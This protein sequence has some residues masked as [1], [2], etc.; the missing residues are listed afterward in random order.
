MSIKG[1]HDMYPYAYTFYLDGE[2]YFVKCNVD[3]NSATCL[4]ELDMAVK[5][6]V[7]KYDAE[8]PR[9]LHYLR[10]EDRAGNSFTIYMKIGTGNPTI[11][12][13][14]KESGEEMP[15]SFVLDIDFYE[16]NDLDS[17]SVVYTASQKDISFPANGAD[18]A[19]G[20][21]AYI[22]EIKWHNEA[23]YQK[24]LEANSFFIF[25]H[26]LFRGYTVSLGL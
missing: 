5:E 26:P 6:R 10:V 11:E 16:K 18:I 12:V 2:A 8:N 14:M 21:I 22:N 25:V 15:T 1:I 23:E 9:N 7:F 17:I 13:I 20:I 19:P 3:V 4:K 24:L